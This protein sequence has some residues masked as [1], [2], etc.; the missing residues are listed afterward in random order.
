VSAGATVDWYDA[1]TGGNKIATGTLEYQATKAGAYYAEARNLTIGCT[2]LDRTK[3]TVII[4]TP[5]CIPV[6]VTR[7][8]TTK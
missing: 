7:K 5:K 3:A 8:K 6:T 4:T 2:S 1:P